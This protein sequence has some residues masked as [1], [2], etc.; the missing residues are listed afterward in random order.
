MKTIFTLSIFLVFVLSTGRL[1]AQLVKVSGSVCNEKDGTFLENVNIYESNSRIGTISDQQGN[2]QL[3]LK[4]G[5]ARIHLDCD[6][7]EDSRQALVLKNDTM[8]AIQLTPLDSK[9]RQKGF[10]FLSK[11]KM[12][13]NIAKRKSPR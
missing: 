2:F 12:A 6:G 5:R 13:E 7:F 8:L 10:G 3:M 11:A 1:H 9:D 4:S